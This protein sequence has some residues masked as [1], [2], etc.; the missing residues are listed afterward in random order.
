MIMDDLAA[1][2]GMSVTE[3]AKAL[4]EEGPKIWDREVKDAQS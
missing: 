3:Y 1:K 2:L 4:L